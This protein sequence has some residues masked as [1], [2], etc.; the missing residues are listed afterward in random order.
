MGSLE[1]V[2]QPDGPR[3]T[4]ASAGMTEFI[5]RTKEY[6]ETRAPHSLPSN[7]ADHTKEKWARKHERAHNDYALLVTR[8]VGPKKFLHSLT[9]QLRGALA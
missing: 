4:N 1:A 8:H 3:T 2:P 7:F 6:T 5:T 9:V